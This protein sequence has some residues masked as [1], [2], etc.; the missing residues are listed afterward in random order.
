MG[1]K[2]NS[3]SPLTPITGG[4]WAG[5]LRGWRDFVSRGAMVSRNAPRWHAYANNLA[6]SPLHLRWRG[7][8]CYWNRILVAAA[9]RLYRGSRRP[10]CCF[11]GACSCTSVDNG[12]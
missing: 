3:S 5:L 9:T 10:V 1:A 4:P 7:A 11:R 2:L 8:L 6:E 12:E